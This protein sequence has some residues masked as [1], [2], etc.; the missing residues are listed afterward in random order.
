MIGECGRGTSALVG[1][2]FSVETGTTALQWMPMIGG[3]T[4]L[5][6]TRSH[7]TCTTGGLR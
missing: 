4:S 5:S 7:S 2:L 6:S 1:V 3:A